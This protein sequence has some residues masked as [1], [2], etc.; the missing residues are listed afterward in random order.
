M[1]TT[2]YLTHNC[3]ASKAPG[4]VL[5]GEAPSSHPA[6]GMVVPAEGEGR[7]PLSQPLLGDA[8]PQLQMGQTRLRPLTQTRAASREEELAPREKPGTRQVTEDHLL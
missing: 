7:V 5:Q 4:Q 2:A 3:K 8:N 1:F 6:P